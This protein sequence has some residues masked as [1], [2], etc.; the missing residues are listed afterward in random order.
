MP[1]NDNDFVS[2]RCHSL[3]LFIVICQSFFAKNSRFKKELV[4][5]HR[6]CAGGN[7]QK[8]AEFDL[9]GDPEQSMLV[10]GYEPSQVQSRLSLA[11]C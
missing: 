6:L 1:T 2:N 3:P 7:Q 5:A 10:L 11:N 9:D 4:H 8:T